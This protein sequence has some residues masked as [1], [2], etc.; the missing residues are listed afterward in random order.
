MQLEEEEPRIIV[1]P[2]ISDEK[3]T[4]LVGR[5]AQ[6]LLGV[7]TAI[8]ESPLGVVWAIAMPL[9]TFLLPLLVKHDPVAYI[10]PLVV[11]VVGTLVVDCLRK[12]GSLGVGHMVCKL[13]TV[14]LYSLLWGHHIF[15]L[16]R[17]HS[18]EVGLFILSAVSIIT[19]LLTVGLEG[20]REFSGN[21]LDNESVGCASTLYMRFFVAFPLL[22]SEFIIYQAEDSFGSSHLYVLRVCV[23]LVWLVWWLGWLG[24][25][26]QTLYFLFNSISILV[27]GNES[28]TTLGSAIIGSV[29]GLVPIAVY[30]ITF[31][32]K[33]E[34]ILQSLIIGSTVSSIFTFI[35]YNRTYP[36]LTP[37]VT[38][39]KAVV[40]IIVEVVICILLVV[41]DSVELFGR[42]SLTPLLAIDFVLFLTFAVLKELARSWSRLGCNCGCFSLKVVRQVER[43]VL[44]VTAA[45]CFLVILNEYQP[46]YLNRFGYDSR[47]SNYIIIPF[48]A[49]RSFKR[50]LTHTTSLSLHGSLFVALIALAAGRGGGGTLLALIMPPLPANPYH[51]ITSIFTIPPKAVH[52][53]ECCYQ[54]IYVLLSLVGLFLY[55]ATLGM[56][57]LTMFFGLPIY[58][59]VLPTEA[60]AEETKSAESSLYTKIVA[61]IDRSL[62]RL[63]D[64]GFYLL[65]VDKYILLLQ[66]KSNCF[67]WGE[68][69]E[70]RGL[71]V[72]EVTSCHSKEGETIDRLVEETWGPNHEGCTTAPCT[73]AIAPYAHHSV[74]VPTQNDIQLTGII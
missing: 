50:C 12:S 10:V 29:V 23:S 57:Q 72:Q 55:L 73:T 46:D 60:E 27:F 32:R 59:P 38:Y 68:L 21:G 48:L 53:N 24:S 54:I 43:L 56:M 42:G 19:S 67:G 3:R 49:Y 36:D 44:R 2:I 34:V 14:A 64:A 39:T 62:F 74:N 22:I 13:V 17:H 71:E 31:Q 15:V 26:Q 35:R 6:T 37:N 20:V 4:Q 63:Y 65:R 45:L 9:L 16:A 52:K 28:Q 47:I 70:L 40:L 61:G 25:L 33:D 7:S 41:L 11:N 5:I 1:A 30:N 51:A 58:Y 66:I 18:H 8:A 69:L